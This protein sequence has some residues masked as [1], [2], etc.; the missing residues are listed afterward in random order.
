MRSYPTNSPQ[1]AM[2]LLALTLLADGATSQA[3]TLVLQAQGVPLGLAPTA[4]DEVLRAVC[5]DWQLSSRRQWGRA[6]D[7]ATLDGL[8][9]EVSDP[10]LRQQV[11]GAAFA[12][13]QA[14]RQLSEGEGRLLARMNREWQPALWA[15]GA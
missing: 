4:T 13:A 7:D 14:D 6:L 11:L 8:L 12:L 5:E 3:E 2:R 1:A 9:A 10:R 15:I